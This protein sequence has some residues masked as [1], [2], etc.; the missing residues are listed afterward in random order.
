VV[1]V[2]KALPEGLRCVQCGAIYNFVKGREYHSGLKEKGRG[3]EGFGQRKTLG[4]VKNVV[5][6]EKRNHCGTK[7]PEKGVLTN[8]ACIFRK[9]ITRR[10]S[11][12]RAFILS[13]GN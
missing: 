9:D 8:L 6:Q 11:K 10:A 13:Q 7:H 1:V 12:K 5:F 4:R 3:E 2:K